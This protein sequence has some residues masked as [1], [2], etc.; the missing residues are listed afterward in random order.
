MTIDPNSS[1][2]SS[3]EVLTQQLRQGSIW[4]WS[5]PSVTDRPLMIPQPGP[6]YC[7]DEY[8]GHGHE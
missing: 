5:G 6:C 3:V 7:D 4:S 2:V 1:L 8:A